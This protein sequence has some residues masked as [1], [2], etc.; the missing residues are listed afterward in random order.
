MS[1]YVEKEEQFEKT[2]SRHQILKVLSDNTIYS[3]TV[4]D[5]FIEDLDSSSP[6]VYVQF[7]VDDATGYIELHDMGIQ[8]EKGANILFESINGVGVSS[9]Y[10]LIG[11]TL[12]CNFEDTLES[13]TILPNEK[14]ISVTFGDID[15]DIPRL[16]DCDSELIEEF[17]GEVCLKSS[18]H[19][20]T[21]EDDKIWEVDISWVTG[22]TDKKNAIEIHIEDE[23]GELVWDMNGPNSFSEDSLPAQFIEHVGQGSMEMLEGST[24]CVI[25]KEHIPSGFDKVSPIEQGSGFYFL[26]SGLVS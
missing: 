16:E 10:D 21:T 13:C 11:G 24:V 6:K 17:W 23:V 25:A 20:V 9:M 1:N 4:E 3:I 15:E 26:G 22:V 14:E 7:K 2:A 8:D 12:K 5:I 19:S 18:Y